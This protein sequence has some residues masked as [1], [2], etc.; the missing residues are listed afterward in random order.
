M[1]L[2]NPTGLLSLK[3]HFAKLRSSATPNCARKGVNGN[4]QAPED[5]GSN[6]WYDSTVQ[7]GNYWSNWD[8]KDNGTADAYPID[9]GA[10]VSDWYPIGGPVDE[11]SQLTAVS[12]LT[13]VLFAF[14]KVGR[15]KQK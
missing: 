2:N 14:C 10:G 9:G 11:G 6:Y 3:N 15:K 13:I 1:A 7:Q 5:V 4:C 8:G 12:F